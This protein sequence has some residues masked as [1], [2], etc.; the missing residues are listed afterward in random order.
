MY[1]ILDRD[2]TSFAPAASNP[3]VVGW[4]LSDEADMMA[5]PGAGYTQQQ[6]VLNSL[7]ADGRLRYSN[8]GKGVLVWESDADAGQFVNQ[9]QDVVSSDHYWFTDPWLIP[10]I[11]APPWFPETAGSMLT[12]PQIKRAANY[13]YQ[14]DR[15]RQLDA[16]DGQR[17]PIYGFVEVGWPFNDTI[18]NGA[19]AITPEQVRAAVWHS[20]IAGARGIIY[21]NHSFGGPCLSQH[22]LREACYAAVRAVV[23]TRMPR[24]SSSP[25]SSTPPPSPA[26]SPPLR[27]CAC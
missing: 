11:P 1:A 18:A 23:K 15:M 26:G 20:I 3:A 16:L 27:T 22:A 19:G 5:G 13:G 7:P 17:Q 10:S 21:F 24:S 25:P 14:I 2:W 6:N 12:A 9:Y 4:E 8:Y